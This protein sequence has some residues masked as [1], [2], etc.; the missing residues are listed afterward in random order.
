MGI[1]SGHLGL[2]PIWLKGTAVLKKDTCPETQDGLPS[3]RTFSINPGFP[4]A[5]N[6]PEK[7][8]ICTLSPDMPS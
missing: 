6:C 2:L 7:K 3:H 8:G 4:C 1:V 5:I